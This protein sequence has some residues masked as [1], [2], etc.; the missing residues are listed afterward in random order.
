MLFSRSGLRAQRTARLAW[1]DSIHRL[2]HIARGLWRSRGCRVVVVFAPTLAAALYYFLIASDQYESEAR[3]V[4]RSA[5]RPEMPGGVGILA[6]LGLVKSQDDPFVVQDFMTSRDAVEQL[7]KEMP[8]RQM[9][10]RDGVDF[11]ARYPS[12]FYGRETEQFYHYFKRMVS[13][14][15]ADKTGITTLTVR[16]F[17][18]ADAYNIVAALLRLS[19]QLVNRINQR[20]Q[21]DAVRASVQELHAAQQR[22]IEAQ[23]K[24][25]DFRNQELIVDPARNAVALAELIA[26][27]SLELSVTQTQIAELRTGSS[28]SPQIPGLQRKVA[29]LEEQITRERARISSDSDNLAQRIASYERLVLERDFSTRL[30]NSAETELA[31]TRSEA[32]RQLLYI[33]RIVQPHE[34]DYSTQ[35]QRTRIVVTVAVSNLLAIAIAWLIFSG[36]K[37]HAAQR[38]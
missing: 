14:S 21:I 31:R 9:F 17:D 7:E 28:N 26:R 23:A 29:A 18:S 19:E 33:E 16:A 35:P 13:V 5:S 37:E 30:M 38:H 24:L 4:I 32:S 25:T 2:Y 10:G 1:D 20:L 34:S 15:Y 36:V 6:Q 22:V 27:L 3:L 11:L 8:L 12:L